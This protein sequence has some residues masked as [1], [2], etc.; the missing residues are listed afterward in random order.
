MTTADGFPT[1][2]HAYIDPMGNVSIE[3]ADDTIDLG[4]TDPP[5][6]ADAVRLIAG[7]GY[8]LAGPWI[9]HEDPVTWHQS[10]WALVERVGPCTAPRSRDDLLCWLDHV[11]AAGVHHFHDVTGDEP[12]R[13]WQC[14]WCHY[15]ADGAYPPA[16]VH[17]VA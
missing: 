15:I 12:E 9:A 7:A 4:D 14:I 3:T 5:W 13:R 6:L 16:E 17:R 1:A 2:D 8:T 10:A 11:I